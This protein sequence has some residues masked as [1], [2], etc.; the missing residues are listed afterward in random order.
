MASNIGKAAITTAKE[1]INVTQGAY[2]TKAQQDRANAQFKAGINNITSGAS[3]FA[4]NPL[5]KSLI[6]NKVDES[7]NPRLFET[8]AL[9]LHPYDVKSTMITYLNNGYIYNC[10][11]NINSF[12]NRIY[13]NVFNVDAYVNYDRNLQLILENDNTFFNRKRYNDLFF[14]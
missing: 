12:F 8:A 1:A 9:K 14:N 4:S 5:L 3:Q 6:P 10:I 11:D 13:M 2:D 7:G